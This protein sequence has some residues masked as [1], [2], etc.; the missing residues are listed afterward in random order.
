MAERH[1]VK[2][3]FDYDE[4]DPKVVERKAVELI[5]SEGAYKFQVSGWQK[6]PD[7]PGGYF[8]V[9]YERR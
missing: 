7:R 2:V 9:S 5:A 1:S 4:T 8:V 3:P 6:N